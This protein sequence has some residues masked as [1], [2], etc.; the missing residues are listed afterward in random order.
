VIAVSWLHSLAMLILNLSLLAWI[1]LYWPDS[2][3]GRV[4]NTLI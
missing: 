4:I 1:K 2:A 3:V